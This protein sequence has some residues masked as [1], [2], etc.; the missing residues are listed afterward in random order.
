MVM[1]RPPLL[2]NVRTDCTAGTAYFRAR[3]DRP[4]APLLPR[5]NKVLTHYFSAAWAACALATD[6]FDQVHGA[7]NAAACCSSVWFLF[8][9]PYQKK[10]CSDLHCKKRTGQVLALITLQI[11]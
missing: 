6:A 11:S 10:M 9:A 4:A 2:S 3:Y 8:R 5:H 1:V 7:V